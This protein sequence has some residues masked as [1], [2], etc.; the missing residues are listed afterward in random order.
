[1]SEA[2]AAAPATNAAPPSVHERLKSFLSS[3]SA[4]PT[5][6]APSGTDGELTENP[7]ASSGGVA[8]PVKASSEKAVPNESAE[9]SEAETVSDDQPAAEVDATDD[10]DAQSEVTQLQTLSELADATGYEL[11]KMLDLA[12]PVK[13]DGKEGTARL[14]DL[15]KSYQLDG[16]INQ[17][18]A[19]LDTDRKTFESKRVESERAIADRLLK[20]D[21]GVKTL[22]R[23]LMGEFQSVDWEKLRVENPSEFN[24][25]YVGYQTRFAEMSDIANGIASEQQRFQTDA[26]QKAAEKLKEE[27]TLLQAKVPEWADTTRRAK[28]KAEIVSYLKD[29]G[30]TQQEFEAIGDHRQLQVVRDAWKWNQLQKSKPAA[31]N[32]VKAAPKLLKPGSQQSRAARDAVASQKDS[33]RLRQTG[34]V[35]DA[36]PAI[37]RAIFR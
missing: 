26:Q 19:S 35:R 8:P 31:L 6:R 16:H 13:I 22:E 7:K 4:E 29:Y 15:V 17:K 28:D 25:R 23:S 37:K 11:D 5:A 20:L 9:A 3:Q 32:K 36:V 14:R 21:A 27:F 12:L 1:M 18:L 33:A 2:E 10:D 24:A 30:I 34:R